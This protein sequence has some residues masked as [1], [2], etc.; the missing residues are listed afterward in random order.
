VSMMNRGTD[1]TW[2]LVMTLGVVQ[3]G[4]GFFSAGPFAR[5]GE[6]MVVTLGALA[7]LRA[8]ADLVTALRLRE[9][10]GV[11]HEVVP[12]SPERAAVVAGYGAGVADFETLP[13]AVARARH[14]VE[15]ADLDSVAARA[16][17]GPAGRVPG[18]DDAAAIAAEGRRHASGV[19][20]A[21]TA[22]L[23]GHD[24]LGR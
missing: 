1:R 2:G 6:L 9:V 24:R 22:L 11:R 17:V 23:A 3:A 10:H 15:A 5:T 4:L 7:L 21:D 18:A 14:R 20:M 19:A 12:V 16:G 13:Q 8:V